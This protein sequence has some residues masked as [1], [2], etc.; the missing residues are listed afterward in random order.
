[1]L[2][3]WLCCRGGWS[4]RFRRVSYCHHGNKNSENIDSN[5]LLLLFQSCQEKGEQ[6]WWLRLLT[7]CLARSFVSVIKVETSTGCRCEM[8]WGRVIKK[9]T[10]REMAL[11]RR[12]ACTVRGNE[13]KSGWEDVGSRADQIDVAESRVLGYSFGINVFKNIDVVVYPK[14][15]KWS[16]NLFIKLQ[17]WTFV[18]NYPHIS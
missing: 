5:H 12:G 8:R 10:G 15:T 13:E 4:D 11:E 16:G 17:M 1:M 6:D 9:K 2:L 18:F 14:I 7:P 3:G